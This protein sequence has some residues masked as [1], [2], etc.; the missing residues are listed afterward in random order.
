[1]LEQ[2]LQQQL[3]E[4][5]DLLYQAAEPLAGPL[6]QAVQT[7]LG[8]LTAGGKLLLTGGALFGSN[9][10]AASSGAAL[11]GALWALTVLGWGL[12]LWALVLA[13]VAGLGNS[14]FHP[15]DYAILSGSIAAERLGRAF[16]IHTFSGFLGG[17]CAPVT[18]LALAQ[19]TDWR[20]A[21]LAVGLVGVAVWALVALVALVAL[22][23]RFPMKTLDVGTV[24]ENEPEVALTV[25]PLRFVAVV[26][27]VAVV[28]L[29]ALV[30]F[31]LNV[32]AV[33]VPV[34]FPLCP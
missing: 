14:V 13:V 12:T 33:T 22:P 34:K 2:R 9:V 19:W 23:V 17:A 8:C 26:A 28:A 16:S 10:L 24:P 1:M 30:A 7:L 31:P 32:G 27:V 15:A 25:P 5:A 4:S 21:L 18:M 29:V 11:A 6:E 20:T 3:F